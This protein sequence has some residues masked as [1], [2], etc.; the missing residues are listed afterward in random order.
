MH[1]DYTPN[2][3]FF[4]SLSCIKTDKTRRILT[5]DNV[6]LPYSKSKMDKNGQK[7]GGRG[8]GMGGDF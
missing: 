8:W 3:R 7:W 6:P 2:K 4:F 1:P 5:T